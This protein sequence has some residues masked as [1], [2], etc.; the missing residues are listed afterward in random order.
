MLEIIGLYKG[1][2]IT[3]FITSDMVYENL[4]WILG[5]MEIDQLGGK[6]PYSSSKA[7]AELAIS[8]YHRTF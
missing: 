1:E 3:V 5:Y 6:D 2:I 8:S 7:L 4:E